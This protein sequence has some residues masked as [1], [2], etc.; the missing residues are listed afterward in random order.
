MLREVVS[1][2]TQK[3]SLAQFISSTLP[4]AR[5]IWGCNSEGMQGEVLQVY[6]YII[7]GHR[8]GHRKTLFKKGWEFF[9]LLNLSSG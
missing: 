9:H 3:S 4:L 1:S 5:A 7:A 2:G 8:T 6:G